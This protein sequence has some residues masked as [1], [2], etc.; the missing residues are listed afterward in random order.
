MMET[1]RCQFCGLPYNERISFR[2]ACLS[3]EKK[4]NSRKSIPFGEVKCEEYG[5]EAGLGP[6][7]YFKPVLE[8]RNK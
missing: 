6:A 2:G 4:I 7:D 5:F 1:F 3:C 8:R